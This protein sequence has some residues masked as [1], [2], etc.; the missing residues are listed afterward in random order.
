MHILVT[1]GA[2]F[3]GSHTCVALLA[4]DHTVLI[5]DN[6]SNSEINTIEKIEYISKKKVNFQLTDVS[7]RNAVSDLFKKN[8]FD[9]VIHFAAYKSISES[10]NKPIEY[11]LNNT[12][13]TLLMAEFCVSNN[14]KKFVYSSSATVY[15][16]GE[17]PFKE[18]MRTTLINHPYGESKLM[19]EL[20]LGN[21]AKAYPDFELTILR[22]FNPIGAHK[23]GLIGE[24]PSGLPNN[25]MPYITQVASGKLKKLKVFGSNYPTPDGT[26]VR[27]YI[28]VMD[29]AEGHVAAIEMSKVGMNV[30]NLGTGIGTSVL[31]LI[32]VF[33]R[34]NSVKIPYEIVE[35]RQGD[36]AISFADV[37]KAQ[38][39]LNWRSSRTL[40]DMCRDSW[41]S[42]KMWQENV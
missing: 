15:S 8:T 23:S 18:S 34:T 5:A 36:A 41:I 10:C 7:D 4:S 27:D 28:H 33:E 22:Y 1:G 14:V 32:E 30:Y 12:Y 35:P 29:I 21:V 31:Q 16:S 40:E 3:I 39:E 13:S 2:G 38:E 11:Y 6:L 42:E 25:I 20:I 17:V 19:S 9:G 37:S 26:G 24:H